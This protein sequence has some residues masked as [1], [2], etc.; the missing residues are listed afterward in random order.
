MTERLAEGSHA[1]LGRIARGGAVNLVGSVVSAVAG[2][3]VVVLVANATSE[4][5]A[6]MVFAAVSV[7][8]ILTA[9]C[10][11]GTDTGLARFVLRY[12][13]QGRYGDIAA[14]LRSAAEPV[15][16]VVVVLSA[17]LFASAD[18]LAPL[19]GLGGDGGA[20]MLR[21]VAVT[22]PFATTNDLMLSVTRSFGRMRPTVAVDSF[23]R[24]LTQVGALLAVG[25][26]GA[27]AVALTGAWMLPYVLTGIVATAIAVRLVMRRTARW[28]EHVAGDRPLVRR[29]FWSYTWP[30]SIARIAQI[31]IQRADI[32]IV[33]ALIDATA[34]AIYTAATRFVVLGQFSSMA[35]QRVLQPR[36]SSLLA[37]DEHD[38]VRDVFKVS[39]AWSIAMSWP[40]Y[41]VTAC[42]APLYLQIFGSGYR[43]DGV[44]VVVIMAIGMMLAMAA[45]PLDTLLLMAGGSTASLV[46]MIT[47]LVVDIGLCFLLIPRMGISGAAVAWASSVVVRNGL[48]FVQV[49]RLNG[50]T[51]F[52]RGATV[53][54]LASL[55]CFGAPLLVV[56]AVT[57]PTLLVVGPTVVV[58][59]VVYA[60]ILWLERGPLALSAFRALVPARFDRS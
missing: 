16:V 7:L 32:I 22:L 48:T 53:V 56:A 38:T 33:A 25:A 42:A 55:G 43:A 21:I 60:G 24:S 2:F 23:L 8:T 46:N 59:G 10:T 37:R 12:E 19:L 44:A 35:I 34:A 36:L 52:S 41:L 18:W 39:T 49:Y 14:A 28:P 29:E 9:T 5:S 54:A 31:A 15:V 27:G 26:A 45:G 11:L 20:A 47:A 13:A 57:E 58:G 50:V 3:L 4:N 17:A 6:G 1:Q 51:P 40:L 30:R